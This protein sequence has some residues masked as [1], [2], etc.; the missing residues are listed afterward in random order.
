LQARS[1]LAS[2]ENGYRYF[3]CMAL[4]I[5]S[6][7]FMVH[8]L[9][10]HDH[11]IKSV[12]LCSYLELISCPYARN[13]YG[14]ISVSLDEILGDPVQAT[15]LRHTIVRFLTRRNVVNGNDP[16]SSFSSF[17]HCHLTLML[18]LPYR[19]PTAPYLNITTNHKPTMSSSHAFVLAALFITAY[20]TFSLPISTSTKNQSL[21]SPVIELCEFTPSCTM[22]HFVMAP[23]QT[24]C[25]FLST[26]LLH[27]T[28]ENCHGCEMRTRR[29][30][31]GLA[32]I[33]L[34][35]YLDRV[36]RYCSTPE[37]LRRVLTRNCS[38]V[39][40]LPRFRGPRTRLLRV[41]CRRRGHGEEYSIISIRPR[42]LRACFLPLLVRT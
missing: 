38:H 24:D 34:P 21:S 2:H 29:I 35:H 17:E 40:W 4:W 3:L 5:S 36:T 30:G 11:R 13:F 26:T 32:S 10:W 25:T 1:T 19:K 15:S 20:V 28:F 18:S 14:H 7:I 9:C 16:H 31:A 42:K 8:I 27:T 41:V 22:D 37:Q 39:G 6:C 23:I 12:Q 33:A